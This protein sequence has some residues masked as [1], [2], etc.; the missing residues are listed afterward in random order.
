MTSE[1]QKV[2]SIICA[3]GGSK[4]L[5]NKNIKKILNEP[6]IARAVRH[7]KLSKTVDR[8]FVSTDSEDIADV[9]KEA[10]AEVPFLRPKEL[11]GDLTTT[12]DTL[13]NALLSFE[14]FCGFKFD[15]GVFLT[16]TDIIRDISWIDQAVDALKN[17]NDLES[18][19][20]GTK[21]HK[22]LLGKK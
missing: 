14:K 20:V 17:D 15:I 1:D 18:A 7:A 5:K 2:V 22:K 12:E 21:T 3:R 8:V 4:G 9:A 19:F 6:L 11:A 13:R 16:A 10:G